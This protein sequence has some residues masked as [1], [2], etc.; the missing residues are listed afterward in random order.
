VDYATTL[1]Y[2]YGLQRFGVKLGLHNMQ[3]LC[4]RIPSLQKPLACVHVAGTNGK[5]SV[6]MMLAE[7][8]RH[9]GLT[10]GLYTSPHLLCFN[11]R[12]RINGTPVS[13]DQIIHYAEIVR[14][15]AAG[16]PA[17]FFEVTTA[18][19][20]LAF[21]QQPVDIAVIETGL[22]GRL[23]ATNIIHPQLCLVTPISQDHAEQLGES[24][25]AIAGEK[26]GIFKP[27]VPVVIGKQPPEALAVL[28]ERAAA[29]GAMVVQAGADY[30]WQGEGD[31][32]DFALHGECLDR[33]PCPLAG[34]HQKDNFAQA[35]AAAMGLRKQ[36]VPIPDLAVRSAGRT[37]VWPG[38][39]EWLGAERKVLT[40]VA[41]NQAGMASMVAYLEEVGLH[42]VQLIVG[43]S[44][45]RD[46]EKVLLPLEKIAGA[47]YA[48][49][50]SDGNGIAPSRIVTWA[51]AHQLKAKA[52]DSVVAALE[53]ALQ[54]ADV[55]HPVVVCGSIYL[56][57]ELQQCLRAGQFRFLR[58]C[59]DCC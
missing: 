49:P 18:M 32:I 9:A 19:A 20:L 28:R 12:I 2:L 53:E 34:R 15:A 48:V 4:R 44:G 25:S 31:T 1:D 38:R 59:S 55:S 22:G 16:I 45:G 50:I 39:L 11:E 21:R 40:D 58:D 30:C 46:P 35:I 27:G 41:H 37:T 3:T 23:D 14:R 7:I 29:C 10:V 36:G 8:L 17:T 56:V 24:L 54:H 5:G 26:A 57:A 42:R 52:C 33:L 51:H 13:Q 47:V 43:L 6:S